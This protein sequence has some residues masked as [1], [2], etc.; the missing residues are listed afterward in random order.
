MKRASTSSNSGSPQKKPSLVPV[1]VPNWEGRSVV[2]KVSL[3]FFEFRDNFNKAKEILDEHGLVVIQGLPQWIEAAES[4]VGPTASPPDHIQKLQTRT[5]PTTDD[6]HANRSPHHG[7]G[8]AGLGYNCIQ[9]LSDKLQSEFRVDFPNTDRG[10]HAV[11]MIPMPGYT[12]NL[13]LMSNPKV[14]SSLFL[15]LRSFYMAYKGATNPVMSTDS[16]KYIVRKQDRGP[17]A[18]QPTL[19]HP[20]IDRY[21]GKSSFLKRIQICFFMDED[22][23]LMFIPMSEYKAPV[24]PTTQGFISVPLTEQVARRAVCAPKGSVVIWRSDVIHFES[25][26]L[27]DKDG[28]ESL[29]FR[30]GPSKLGYRL[31]F[32]IGFHDSQLDRETRRMLARYA[33][34]GWSPSCYKH[35]NKNNEIGK[36]VVNRRTTRWKVPYEN[37][38]YM[39]PEHTDDLRAFFKE[40]HDKVHDPNEQVPQAVYDMW[41]V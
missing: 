4:L 14:F 24:S 37:A 13:E 5:Y 34:F 20:H 31:R 1:D 19:T 21:E 6:P 3:S 15:T 23:P 10:E 32:Y 29:T 25:T 17:E 26:I 16:Y 38:K 40:V 33:Y 12:M 28:N 7:C 8:H 39:K 2:E 36:E 18:T 9:F 22:H 27:K 30:P 11:E 35:H 41:S